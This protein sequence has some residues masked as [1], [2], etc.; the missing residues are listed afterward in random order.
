MGK[1]G[2]V[3]IPLGGKENLGFILEP[4]KRF[5]MNN[6]VPVPLE[7]GSNVAV[8]FLEL[9]TLALIRFGGI[10]GKTFPFKSFC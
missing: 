9:P 8:F 5:G 2:S 7:R 4:A 10:F 1:A 6:P 3:M